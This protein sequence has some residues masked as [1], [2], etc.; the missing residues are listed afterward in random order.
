MPYR[1][2]RGQF[3]NFVEES[4]RELPKRFSEYFTN[5]SVVI[6]DIPD[7]DTV[8]GLGVPG[9]ELM[10]LF[11]GSAL[12]EKHEMLGLPYPLPDEIILYQKNIEA[13]CSSEDCLREEIRLTVVHELGHYFGMTEEELQ[14]Y[15]D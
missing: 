2:T 5:I 14:E 10:G 8:R 3:Q 13:A 1:V 9:N 12:D 4:L 6:E 15:E 11:R 7:A